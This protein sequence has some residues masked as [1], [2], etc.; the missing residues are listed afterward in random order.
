MITV[1][2]AAARWACSSVD[3]RNKMTVIAPYD[4]DEK[5]VL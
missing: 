5:K 3:T 2:A 4:K 1:E